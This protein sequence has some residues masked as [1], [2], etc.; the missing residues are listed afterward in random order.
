VSYNSDGLPRALPP[1]AELLQQI[2]ERFFAN[3][4]LLS[5]EMPRSGVGGTYQPARRVDSN[6]FRLRGLFEQMTIR[7]A[8][9][10]LTIR[11]AML[12]FDAP[13]EPIGPNR[14]RWGGREI[15]FHRSGPSVVMQL[16]SPVLQFVQVAWW[17]NAGLVL[18]AVMIGLVVAVTALMVSGIGMLRRSLTLG[19]AITRRLRA[20]TRW[21]LM[22]QVLAICAAFWLVL[23]G[24][25]LAA[26]SSPVVV[27]L[28]L[29]IYA[30]AWTAVALTRLASW[31]CARLI[32]TGAGWW[33]V[34]RESLLSLV[35]VMLTAFCLYWR[36][37]GTS[38]EF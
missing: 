5:A 18:P 10:T 11:P 38:L 19:D 30:A 1:T 37:A 36:I 33:A 35:V 24:W 2:A 28:G 20:A 4:G 16:G 14:F 15:S 7:R 12:P 25:P 13:M 21:V 27:P 23:W 6:V 17:A 29:G 22:L 34:T 31:H 3:D 9:R 32:N 26:M 8:E